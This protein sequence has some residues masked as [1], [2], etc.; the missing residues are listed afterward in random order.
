MKRL[1]LTA[2]VTL[3]LSACSGSYVMHTN[4]GRSIVTEGKPKVDNDTGMIRYKD[5][6]G[7]VQQISR[8]DVKE[9]VKIGQ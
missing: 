2:V 9:M 6:D 1:L 5:A 4:D 7:K 8:S 3:L